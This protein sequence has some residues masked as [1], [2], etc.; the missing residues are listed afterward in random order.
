LFSAST[1]PSLMSLCSLRRSIVIPLSCSLSTTSRVVSSA[2]G[3]VSPFFRFCRTL[4]RDSSRWS[5]YRVSSSSGKYRCRATYTLPGTTGYKLASRYLP[6]SIVAPVPW[7]G[8]EVAPLR[9][10]LIQGIEEVFQQVLRFLAVPPWMILVRG[11]HRGLSVLL[12]SVLPE[13]VKES[14]NQV[15]RPHR[16]MAERLIFPFRA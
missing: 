16:S 10:D 7:V 6:K 8:A 2:T 14:G 5:G 15:L 9:R 1:L 12:G 4:P 11:N 3:V 13:N